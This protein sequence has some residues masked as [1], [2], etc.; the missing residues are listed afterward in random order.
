MGRQKGQSQR[1][2]GNVRP[3]NSGRA[4]NRFSENQG[5][6]GF[7][8]LSGDLGYVPV[9]KSLEED[10]D[11]AIDAD[12]RVTLCKLY[13]KDITTKLKALAEFND[14]C[15]SKDTSDVISILPYWA[16]IYN[17]LS[18][19]CDRRIRESIQNAVQKLS[20]YAGKDIA[21]Y[22]KDIMGCWWISQSDSYSPA[23]SA[24]RRAF[25]TAF[26]TTEK[27]LK[28]IIFCHKEILHAI[29][30]NVF[31][32][33]KVPAQ[34]KDDFDKEQQ[35][36]MISSSLSALASLLQN[37]GKERMSKN[38]PE[39]LDLIISNQRF[40]KFPKHKAPIIR[41]A[42]YQ[43]VVA[44][45]VSIPD[46]IEQHLPTICKCVLCKLDDPNPILCRSLWDAVDALIDTFEDWHSHV[47]IRKGF[48][49]QLYSVLKGGFH[50][51]ARVVAPHML[52]LL[53]NFPSSLAVVSIYQEIFKCLE[54]G[55][56][57]ENVQRSQ[58]DTTA[59]V[60]AMV[61]CIQ[62]VICRSVETSDMP[63]WNSIEL[64]L[65]KLLLPLLEK[66]V[67]EPGIHQFLSLSLHHL[68]AQTILILSEKASLETAK[69]DIFIK[70]CDSIW[71]EIMRI[72]NVVIT[73]E[74]GIDER[75]R[76]TAFVKFLNIVRDSSTLTTKPKRVKFFQAGA[77]PDVS[78]DVI[79]DK[80]KE[81]G[82]PFLIANLED[83]LCTLTQTTL[84]FDTNV[85]WKLHLLS[86]IMSKFASRSL[87][88]KFFTSPAN[89][90]SSES[91]SEDYALKFLLK[92]IKPMIKEA[93]IET[94]SIK[95]DG[96]ILSTLIYSCV[97]HSDNAG[98]FLQNLFV[99]LNNANST[100][101][102]VSLGQLLIN[103]DQEQ[104]QKWRISWLSG[105]ESSFSKFLLFLVNRL[106]PSS[107]DNESEEWLLIC[108]ALKFHF[109]LEG[110]N[111]SSSPVS[112]HPCIIMIVQRLA[113]FLDSDVS[114]HSALKITK[115][116]FSTLDPCRNYSLFV[117]LY[118]EFRNTFYFLHTIC[119]SLRSKE[120]ELVFK[121]T[122]DILMT[123]V[124]GSYESQNKA[125]HLLMEVAALF[126]E[127]LSKSDVADE[128]QV[129]LIS[130]VMQWYAEVFIHHEVSQEFVSDWVT[131][132]LPTELLFCKY[133]P[134]MDSD[135]WLDTMPRENALTSTGSS[136]LKESSECLDFRSITQRFYSIAEK[137]GSFLLVNYPSLKENSR[138]FTI[139]VEALL[140]NALSQNSA[141]EL[142][143]WPDPEL[144]FTTLDKV[145]TKSMSDGR[146]W[147]VCFHQI[148]AEIESLNFEKRDDLLM[149][150]NLEE[151]VLTEPIAQTIV[152]YIQKCAQKCQ[153]NIIL[154][155]VLPKF[156]EKQQQLAEN[157]T[158]RNII[159]RIMAILMS[160]LEALHPKSQVETSIGYDILVKL[161]FW[162][163]TNGN[164]F[165]FDCDLS[166]AGKEIIV[167]NTTTAQLIK[168]VIQIS[169]S[170]L[171][172]EMW[173][174]VQCSLVSWMESVCMTLEKSTPYPQDIL[175]LL[176]SSC[177]LMI[178]LSEYLRSEAA[179]N[180]PTLPS[181]LTTEW[182][183][184]FEP[185]AHATLVPIFIWL[186]ENPN[187]DD[188]LLGKLLQC[189]STI[190]P[191]SLLSCSSRLESYLLPDSQLAN[192]V[193]T[194]LHHLG[195]ALLPK[196]QNYTQQAISYSLLSRLAGQV[197][198]LENGELCS[199]FQPP[200]HLVN[201]LKAVSA[202][203]EEVCHQSVERFQ[204]RSKVRK[205]V[206]SEEESVDGPEEVEMMQ[207]Q[208]EEF[209]NDQLHF[210][211]PESVC[212]L[213]VW[214]LLIFLTH[215]IPSEKRPEY[216]AELTGDSITSIQNHLLPTMLQMLPKNPRT[217]KTTMF[218]IKF[219]PLKEN[220]N[221]YSSVQ[222]LACSLYKD[223]LISTPVIVRTWYASLNKLVSATVEEYTSKFVS[224]V[225]CKEELNMISQSKPPP[226]MQVRSR[227]AT[228]EVVAVYEVVDAEFEISIQLPPNHPLTPAQVNT[229]KRVGVATSQWRY[230]MLQMTMLLQHQNG[231]ILDALLLWKQ[232]V[233]KRLDG[234]EECM[235][236]FSVVY[237]SNAQSLPKLQCK[238]CRKRYHP[239]CLYKWFDTS[240][241]ST[242]PL[243][244]S[245]MMF[246]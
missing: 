71:K 113:E 94:Q 42:F 112:I 159:T 168:I 21:P 178:T 211:N 8:S 22:L 54:I 79:S 63:D 244:R 11:V 15:Q 87:F 203:V 81:C 193:Q 122:L 57:A 234:L 108:N 20:Q 115:V 67:K 50:G 95:E 3:S 106:V 143:G 19:D 103:N 202:S 237:G 177:Q 72:G 190:A 46:Q 226:S 107:F 162:K 184:F 137:L 157:E 209:E 93:C 236:C 130:S 218:D 210:H 205:D 121:R 199:S 208:A 135:M 169:P 73:K 118:S 88:E 29:Q 183:E 160:V 117:A 4:A 148:L 185:G 109:S 39:S 187:L 110:V 171:S 2:K 33:P 213:L 245:P 189:F 145:V 126:L 155:W 136:K 120:A 116:I 104:N 30:M 74:D 53:R 212:Y 246:R 216:M 227:F 242:C 207:D 176:Q 220:L 164:L 58:I 240:N 173:D 222:H 90:F 1:T 119:C 129:D 102:C 206:S 158:E 147:L 175:L 229:V 191:V 86:Q 134:S 149:A 219:D 84:M 6:V 40:W 68:V 154:Q 180:D 198:K 174:F 75:K 215:H 23:A 65:Q 69:Q 26:P 64:V 146:G 47:D 98:E 89:D 28:A 131:A 142:C 150:F 200:H 192:P 31:S 239:E 111:T 233:D 25:E 133:R 170:T 140:A 17:K 77:E 36:R 228:R 127:H 165:L 14:L 24:A 221:E 223:I 243:C 161:I 144:I 186:H 182:F 92:H 201:V 241:Q 188:K 167:F 230:W 82:R 179:V 124:L 231:T 99:D 166:D 138:F 51:N 34:N 181:S 91:R 70:I 96:L 37:L 172:S 196:N 97:E 52:T 132:L 45:C 9:M 217:N 35:E 224:P 83:M 48:L 114:V 152:V 153:L 232:K 38:S 141:V 156:L 139:F 123:G 214:K 59:V 163:A 235:I 27:Q 238:T 12:F 194:L 13:K 78:N 85:K 16:R 76:V 61:E 43:V 60:T 197:F 128:T 55:L 151:S 56:N 204:V 80:H 125:S 225:I 44:M 105:C 32:A 49:P 100:A 195:Y 66:S 101:L 7:S 62:F 41:A 18:F 5:F 10:N